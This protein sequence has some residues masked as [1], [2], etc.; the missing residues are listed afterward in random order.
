MFPEIF[1]IGPFAL[2]SY[3]LTLAISFFVGLYYIV[4]RSRREGIDQNFAIN[5]AFIEIFTG[6]LGARL[7]FV[8]VHLSEYTS[9][10]WSAVNPFGS[11]GQFG[12][13]GLNLYGGVVCAIIAAFIYIKKKRQS[14]W[15]VLDIFAPALAL[16]IFITRIGCFLNGC[17]FGTPTDLPFCVHFPDGSIPYSFFGDQCLHPTQLYSSLYGLILF[18][19]LI[20]LDKRKKFYGATFSYLLMFEAMFRFAIEYV[21]YYEPAM[22][23]S[24]TGIS[25]TYNHLIAIML[26]L[27]GL[28]IRLKLRRSSSV[29]R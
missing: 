15:Q 18:V 28:T 2:R 4:R 12:I 13:S 3:G 11:G 7:F 27:L 14:L 20:L 9:D 26:F 1:Q 5:L 22:I 25:F 6:L 8:L 24:V 10:P 23:I 16:G 19:A 17:C 29:A 21:R